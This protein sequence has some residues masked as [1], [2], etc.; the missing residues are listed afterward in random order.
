MV[1][2]CA[3]AC[4]YMDLLPSMRDMLIHGSNENGVETAD[5]VATKQFHTSH[6]SQ[7]ARQ[8]LRRVIRVQKGSTSNQ[9]AIAGQLAPPSHHNPEPLH[10]PPPSHVAVWHAQHIEE[11]T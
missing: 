10:R 5:V 1:A 4:A 9:Q 8:H 2:A 6:T 11:P 7:P 3:H